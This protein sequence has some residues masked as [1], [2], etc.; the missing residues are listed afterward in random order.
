MTHGVIPDEPARS[1]RRVRRTRKLIQDAFLELTVE[2]GFAAVTVRDIAERAGV[3][4]ATFYRHYQDK[5]DLLEHYSEEV[6]LLLDTLDEAAP[7]ATTPA[8]Q[9]RDGSVKV[10]D[11]P[12]AGLIKLFEHV[13]AH[14][15]FYR[16]MLGKSG[17]PAFGGRIQ[18][19]IQTRL[20]GSLPEA[21]HGQPLAEVFLSYVASGSVGVLLWW[22][23][24]DL[25]YSSVEMAALGVRLSA[26][27]LGAILH[28]S[29]QVSKPSSRT[30]GSK[31]E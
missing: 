13:R 7:E 16:V 14:A 30:V 12:S 6:Y 10:P 9:Y 17:D 8:V 25:P 23:E 29:T 5:F 26:A 24:H 1:D 2:K 28:I 4:R 20:R 21:L 22:L 11:K 31:R 27:D 15:T 18:R 3:N 19:Y